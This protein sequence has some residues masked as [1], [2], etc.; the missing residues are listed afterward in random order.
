MHCY[1]LIYIYAVEHTV[2]FPLMCSYRMFFWTSS[3]SAEHYCFFKRNLLT[4][5][6]QT[7]LLNGLVTKC[8][9]RKLLLPYK[10]EPSIAH[11]LAGLFTHYKL[12]TARPVLVISPI[13]K[14]FNQLHVIFIHATSRE[15]FCNKYAVVDLFQTT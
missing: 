2:N 5:L 8:I 6:L 14:T 9:P 15:W 12:L 3:H 10:I 4:V 1:K 13:F 7:E 11:I